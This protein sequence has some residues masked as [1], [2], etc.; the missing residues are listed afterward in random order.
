MMNNYIISAS[1]F[2]DSLVKEMDVELFIKQYQT[3]NHDKFSDSIPLEAE[4]LSQYYELSFNYATKFYTN[5]KLDFWS[6]LFET[7]RNLQPFMVIEIDS[8]LEFRK[9]ER[10]KES[11]HNK[12]NLYNSFIN[13]ISETFS[14]NSVIRKTQSDTFEIALNSAA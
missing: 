11:I 14:T 10:V 5:T 2:L 12:H 8:Y 13:K 7:H 9:T 4:I 3:L 1:E 6:M